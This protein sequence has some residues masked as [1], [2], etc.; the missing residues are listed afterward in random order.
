MAMRLHSLRNAPSLYRVTY[1]YGANIYHTL[2]IP[3]HDL[4]IHYETYG[5]P[6][7]IK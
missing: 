1:V 3:D 6:I 7:S 2:K 4:S 5:S